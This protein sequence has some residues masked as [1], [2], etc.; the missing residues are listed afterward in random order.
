MRCGRLALAMLNYHDAPTAVS[1]RRRDA[2]DG[3]C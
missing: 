3:H 1:A 2:T